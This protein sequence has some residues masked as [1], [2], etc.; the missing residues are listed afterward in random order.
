MQN[1]RKE[2]QKC[3]KENIQTLA[4]NSWMRVYAGRGPPASSDS[5][6][7]CTMSTF[8]IRARVLGDS[9][10]VT[11]VSKRAAFLLRGKERR[12]VPL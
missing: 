5:N 12:E 11:L 10:D 8:S 3:P 4:M 7:S 1:K 9:E 6:I 2:T